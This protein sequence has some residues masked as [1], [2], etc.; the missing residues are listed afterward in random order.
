MPSPPAIRQPKEPALSTP[1]AADPAAQPASDVTEVGRRYFAAVNDHDVEGMLACWHPDGEEVISG[2]TIPLPD[3]FR[4]YFTS[5][6]PPSP[7]CG[8]RAWTRW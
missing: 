1:A 2:E 5:C 3:G 6:S 7:T 4:A 8:W